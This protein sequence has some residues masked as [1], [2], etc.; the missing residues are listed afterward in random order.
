MSEIVKLRTRSEIDEEAAIWTWRMDS[1]EATAADQLAFDSW[2]RLDPRH[3]RAMDELSKVWNALDGLAE[4]KRDE[5]IATF[6]NAA[7]PRAQRRG[8]RN[9]WFAAAM[10][11]VAVIGALWLRSGSE[12][13]TLATAVGQQRNVSLAD[14]SVVELNT[15]TI[16]ETNLGRRLREIYLHKGEAHFKVAHDSSRPFLVHAGDAVVRAVGTQFEV[17]VRSD[18]HVDVVVNE[19]RV[20]VQADTPRAGSAQ[21]GAQSHAHSPV[22]AMACRY[23]RPSLKSSATRMPESS[24]ATRKSRRCASAG[25]LGPTICRE[26]SRPWKRP[27][28]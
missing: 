24:S 21:F 15:N 9:W 1:G 12:S 8:R 23:R 3:R 18:Q 14:G 10:I 25:A 27:C 20:E 7:H 19:G 11:T 28:R 26:Y 5:K 2:L 4:A 22:A 13:Q 17:R 16:V 6:A